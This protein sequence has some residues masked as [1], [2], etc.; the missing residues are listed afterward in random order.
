MKTSQFTQS[1]SFHFH[2]E[3]T[4]ELTVLRVIYKIHVVAVSCHVSR[5]LIYSQLQ[6][7]VI[8]IIIIISS[9]TVTCRWLLHHH[10]I[11]SLTQRYILRP[12][13]NNV[14]SL[15]FCLYFFLFVYSVFGIVCMIFF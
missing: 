2:F 7:L 14:S 5:Q 3:L 11:P 8:I 13:I 10:D 12:S 9:N 6:I 1:N 4:L 15:F